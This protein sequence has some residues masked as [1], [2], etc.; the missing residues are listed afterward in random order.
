MTENE[1]REKIAYL[2]P[3]SS[4]GMAERAA[5]LLRS[6]AIDMEDT[7]ERGPYWYAKAIMTAVL[8]DEAQQYLPGIGGRADFMKE[9]KNLRRF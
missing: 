7:A 4:H 9:V 1:L 6:G 3:Q 2:I 5:K 8:E